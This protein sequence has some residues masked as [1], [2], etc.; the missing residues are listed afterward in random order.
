MTIADF[1][2]LTKKEPEKSLVEGKQ[3]SS[4]RDNKG[5]VS[6]R[7]RGG[8][9]KRLYRMIDFRQTGKFGIPANVVA[10]GNPCRVVRELGS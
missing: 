8:G 7:F 5:R 3:R 6:S 1:S 9:H 10:V 4:G 2:W